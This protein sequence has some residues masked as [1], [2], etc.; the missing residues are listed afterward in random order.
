MSYN[1]AYGNAIGTV[2]FDAIERHVI[3][4]SRMFTSKK[5]CCW[6]FEDEGGVVTKEISG[7]R[8]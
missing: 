7:P 3:H 1:R 5:A 8:L 4:A 6:G 2:H